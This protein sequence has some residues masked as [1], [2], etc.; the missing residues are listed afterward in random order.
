MKYILLITEND[1]PGISA[2]VSASMELRGISRY[3]YYMRKFLFAITIVFF[4]F[5]CSHVVSRETRERIDSGINPQELFQSPDT[6]IGKTVILGGF[7][8]GTKNSNEGAYIEVV[9]NPLDQL[10]RP[11]DPDISHGR[12]IIV[13]MGVIDSAIYT[14]G[15]KVTVAGEVMGTKVQPLGE[16]EYPYVL[17]KSRELHLIAP[18]QRIPVHFSIG[19]WQSF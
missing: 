10:G 17:I 1:R 2:G 3:N 15:R 8:A 5:G 16:I 4:L 18:R 7:I 13:Y 9:Q 12:F 19:I 11:V 6:F 14:Q